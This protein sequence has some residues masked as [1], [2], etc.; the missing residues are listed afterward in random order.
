M[1]VD[2]HGETLGVLVKMPFDDGTV[3]QFV[4]ASVVEVIR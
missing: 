2:D 1:T 3:D 4:P